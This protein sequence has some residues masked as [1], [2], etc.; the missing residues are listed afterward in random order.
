MIKLRRETCKYRHEL[1]YICD[2][3]SLQIIEKKLMSIMRPDPHADANGEYLIR[4][5]YFDDFQHTCFNENENGVDPREKFRIRSYNLSKQRISLE[6]KKKKS[7]MTGKDIVI[8]PERTMSKMVWGR[9]QES[10]ITGIHPL[11]DEW[12]IKYRTNQ[13]KPVMMGEYVRKPLIYNPGN[14]R[15]TF[16]RNICASRQIEG[17]FDHRIS[18]I[19]V[20]PTGYH[21]LE[22]KYD[23][24]LPDMIYQLIEDGH[25]IQT[26]FSKFYLGCKALGGNVYEL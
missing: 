4:S 24:F 22:V 11:L 16:D 9:V 19:S 25:M 1:K 3:I 14:V 7:N 18:R 2:N 5:I 13:L 6:K 12:Y 10:E 15:I 23:D 17:F 26:T 8:I 20:L 21:I